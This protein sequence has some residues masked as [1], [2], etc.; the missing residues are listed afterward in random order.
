[1]AFTTVQDPH[2]AGGLGHLLGYTDLEAPF[3]K[4]PPKSMPRHSPNLTAPQGPLDPGAE[5]GV[6]ASCFALLD[7]SIASRVTSTQARETRGCQSPRG[8]ESWF[9]WACR[10]LPSLDHLSACL[11]PCSGSPTPLASHV[12]TCRTVPAPNGR[13]FQLGAA[14]SYRTGRHLP[15]PSLPGLRNG[16]LLG[17]NRFQL[18]TCE[19]GAGSL[20][21]VL[22]TETEIQ[23]KPRWR[24]G[25]TGGGASH[26]LKKLVCPVWCFRDWFA[27]PP[28]PV[29]IEQH[30]AN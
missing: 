20:L 5:P 7:V 30:T 11:N 26:E 14:Q 2:V 6:G 17:P 3:L 4:T 16:G 9:L 13:T 19:V 27:S 21:L 22:Q 29:W 24:L 12:P 28:R 8:S 23:E 1:M 15:A 25:T 18:V 10:V